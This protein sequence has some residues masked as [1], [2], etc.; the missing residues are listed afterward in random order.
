MDIDKRFEFY[1]KIYFS[2]LD[3]MNKVL[4]RFPVLIAGMA[5]ILNAYIFIIGFDGF[6]GLPE[7]LKLLFVFLM[8]FCMTILLFF[9]YRTFAPLKYHTISILTELEVKRTEFCLHELRQK[10]WNSGEDN[11]P[12]VLED[13]AED[14]FKDDL[15]RC[16]VQYS[17]HNRILNNK[18]R[19]YFSKTLNYICINFGLCLVML[20]SSLLIGV[21]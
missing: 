19:E 16:F 11:V 15:L 4:S 6:S 20:A 10:E 12:K 7:A 9:M 2:E 21:Y 14:L 17:S 3:E 8:F 13:S 18:R 1:E 5:L